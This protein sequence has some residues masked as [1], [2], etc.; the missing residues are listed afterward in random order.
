MIVA[1]GAAVFRQPNEGDLD[2]LV[3]GCLA[4]ATRPSFING[5]LGNDILQGTLS[6]DVTNAGNGDDKLN[7]LAGND[8]PHGQGDSDIMD[9]GD[10]DDTL[11]GQGR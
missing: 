8:I 10:G 6:D 2:L 11:N 3:D 7:G 9:G 5:T 4:L 1:E